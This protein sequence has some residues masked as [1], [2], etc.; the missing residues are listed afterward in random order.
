VPSVAG[1]PTPM[2]T[3]NAILSLSDNPELEGALMVEE[4]PV[5]VGEEVSKASLLII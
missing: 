3:P 5:C 2:P 1:S 4:E